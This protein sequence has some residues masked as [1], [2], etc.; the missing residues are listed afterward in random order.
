MPNNFELARTKRGA[1]EYDDVYIPLGGNEQ[2]FNA[3][4]D[5]DRFLVVQRDNT[6][7]VITRK[8]LF[9]AWGNATLIN[10]PKRTTQLVEHCKTSHNPNNCIDLREIYKAASMPVRILSF[11]SAFR[12]LPLTQSEFIGRDIYALMH[13]LAP[14]QKPGYLKIENSTLKVGYKEGAGVVIGMNGK[15]ILL[16]RNALRRIHY[17]IYIDSPSQGTYD[18]YQPELMYTPEELDRI[19]K[20]RKDFLREHAVR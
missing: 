4:T 5:V 13:S 15:N 11:F 17:R 12:E 20:D 8:Q 19:N 10:M 6:S 7:Y 18:T 1:V 2:L 14:G 9:K 3:L 16:F